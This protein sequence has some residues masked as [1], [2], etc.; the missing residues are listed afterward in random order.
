MK[1]K[2]TVMALALC[3]AVAGGALAFA[4]CGDDI[5]QDRA[6]PPLAAPTNGVAN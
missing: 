5:D 6:L 1:I 2:K 3:V 4:A